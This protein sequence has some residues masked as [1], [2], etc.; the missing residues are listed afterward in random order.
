MLCA[1]HNDEWRYITDNPEYA[2][3]GCIYN[4]GDVINAV[5][6]VSASAPS[7]QKIVKEGQL[8]ILRDGKIYN[9]M[10]WKLGNNPDRKC[11]DTRRRRIFPNGIRE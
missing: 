11:F 2:P 6:G 5:E 1:Y 3:L 10:E 7:V 4:E 8:L 9:I